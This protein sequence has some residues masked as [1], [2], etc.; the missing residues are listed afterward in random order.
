MSSTSVHGV[1]ADLERRPV[2]V[3]AQQPADGVKVEDFLHRPRQ[4]I[5]AQFL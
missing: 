5:N 3:A 2:G 4:I 1:D